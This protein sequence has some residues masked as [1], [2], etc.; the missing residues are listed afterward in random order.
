MSA[1]NL[2]LI[3][4]AS[5][6]LAFG[7]Q[8]VVFAW[9][10]TIVLHEPAQLVGWAQ[11]ALLAPGMLLM[12]ISGALAD[13]LG[14]DRQALLAQM[15]AAIIPW[16]LI[17]ALQ[18]GWLDFSVMIIYALLMGIAQTFVTPARDGLLNHIAEGKVQRMVLLTSLTQFSCQIVGNSLAAFAD[19]WGATVILML[20]SGF[21]S[22]GVIA[23]ALIS[24]S[25][26][27]KPEQSKTNLLHGL[28]EGAGTVWRS[29]VMRNI[30][31]QNVAMALFFMGCFIVCFPLAV[32]DVFNGSA[33]DLALLNALNGLGLALTIVVLLRLGYVRRA[34]RALLL[35]Q[36]LGALALGASGFVGVF[37]AFV[38]LIF[39]WGMCGG[40]AMPMSRTLMQELAP[41]A[42]RA[43]VMSFY[44]FSFMGAGPLGTL[45]CGYLAASIGPQNA[46][47]VCATMMLCVS[48]VMR[49]ATGLWQF[50]FEKERV[51]M[52]ESAGASEQA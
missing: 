49:F 45:F 15:M 36:G 27:A 8:A 34:G 26:V 7:M 41:P 10:V 3:A 25:G 32:R 4:T 12:L 24:R 44:A 31:V 1:R 29:P 22:V 37:P 16:I 5:W 21:L 46:I 17:A 30:L 40:M 2:Y 19:T 18:Q 42:Q 48:V 14:T 35:S 11:T 39:V 52:P 47:I 13:R 33:N 23:Y 43:R 51:N 50:D 28:L 6:F 9:L 38:L 20:Q